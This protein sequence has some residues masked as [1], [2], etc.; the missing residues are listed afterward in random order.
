MASSSRQGPAK[1]RGA[2]EALRLEEDAARRRNWKR[3]GPYLS[4]RQWGTVREDYSKDGNAWAYFPFEHARSRAYRWGEDGIHGWCDR[5]QLLVFAPA[6]WNGSDPIVKE[7][8]FGLSGPQG[9][10]GEDVKELYYYLDGTPTHSYMKALYKY[11]QREFPYAWLVSENAR[12]S[13]A[14]REFEIL[15]TGIFDDDKYFDIFV[16]YAKAD[17]DDVLIRITAVNRGR[18]PAPLELLPTVWYRNTWSWGDGERRPRM[19]EARP[20]GSLRAVD[21]DLEAYGRMRLWCDGEPELLFTEN[22]SNA[23]RLWG[24]ENES[25]YVK[26]GIDEYVVRGLPSVNPEKV[27]TRAAARYR[28]RILPGDS[29]VLRLRLNPVASPA[30]PFGAEFDRIFEERIAEAEDF[31]ATVCPE[32][33]SPDAHAVQRQAYAGMLWC[34]QYYGYEVRRWLQGDPGQPPPPS[35]R[36]HGRNAHW[37]HLYNADVLSMPDDW[38]YPWYASWDHAFHCLTLALIDPELAKQQ[39]ILLT[40]EWYMHP[41]GQL[42]AYEWALSDVNPPVQAWA[43]WRVFKIDRKRRGQADRAFLVRMFHKLLLNFTWWVNR[44]D[45]AGSN[46]FEGGFLGLDNVGVF[47]RSNPPPLGGTL[48]Q[49]DGTSW[50]GMYCLHM[51]AIALELAVDEPAYEDVAS[52]FFE[53]FVYICSA[54]NGSGSR[55]ELWDDHDGFYYDV[56]DFPDGRDLPM[57]IRSM[58]GLIPLFAVETLEPQVADRF[59]AF[60]RRLR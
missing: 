59:P 24:V 42:P 21:I 39:L 6:F 47:D 50:M 31:Y 7:R 22:E 4:Q 19:R 44:K 27:G 5:H 36:Q 35:E 43:A 55:V 57:K 58:V 45:S 51:A 25:P 38:E 17:P 1:S 33:L 49:T 56:L 18:D 48:L 28:K 10:H 14:D 46:I 26:D 54:M 30:A 13:K 2:A 40:R 52:K 41:N 53:H 60:R 12:R 29:A 37:R 23:K 34:K 15:D 8:L 11:P 16:E 32:A 3:W 20:K 9:N